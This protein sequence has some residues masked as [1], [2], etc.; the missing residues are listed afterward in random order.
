VK[1]FT[2]SVG[3]LSQHRI[4][5]DIK[6]AISIVAEPLK[7]VEAEITAQSE[8][9]DPA[10]RP[11]IAHAVASSGKRLR[12]ALA[13]LSGRA[14]GG[15]TS[16]DHLKLA[17]IIELIHVATLVHDDIMD[18]AEMRRG[19]PTANAK[20]GNSTSVLLGDTLFAHALKLATSYDDLSI[21]RQIASAACD[22][23]TGEILQTQRRFDLKLQESDY[24]RI[25]EMKTAALF[26]V[27][28]RVGA[29][30]SN[31]PEPVMD[32]F[33]AYGRKL[34]T[35]YQIYDDCL[36]L[37]GDESRA[38]KTLGSDVRKG[39][40]TLPIL[41]LLNEHAN[42]HH[43]EVSKMLLSAEEADIASLARLSRET[44]ALNDAVEVA[45]S[46]IREAIEGLQ[47]VSQN[48]AT[49]ALC[50]VGECVME[51]VGGFAD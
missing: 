50:N 29:Q 32:A 48:D 20:W 51:L 30:L 36:D 33:E 40:L 17:L 4:S 9:F 22:V 6:A 18:G 34:G 46:M 26:A 47:A 38:G 3:L 28:A 45:Q 11:Y 49:D 25:I 16:E 43:P 23:C 42:G 21:S 7:R 39:K 15:S 13:L 8:Q 5:R 14:A 31:A 35:A 44:G 10:V 2:N 19:L 24:Y 37:V 12:P 41:R 27:A 1:N